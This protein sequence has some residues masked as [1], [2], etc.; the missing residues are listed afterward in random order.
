MKL[1]DRDV[2]RRLERLRAEVASDPAVLNDA[3]QVLEAAAVGLAPVDT[4]NLEASW[5][6]E[7]RRG[8]GGPS[9]DFGFGAPY[10]AEVHE[11]PEYARGPR[12]QAKP[13]NE[14]GEAGPGY[15]LRA[16]RGVG[17]RLME[18]IRA[19]LER[20]VRERLK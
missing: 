5:A 20:R 2:Q 15:L 8:P 11:L 12:T 13:G 17:P 1:D 6:Q 14:Y 9:A 10:A 16:M 3:L 4:G 7:T 18:V 19:T